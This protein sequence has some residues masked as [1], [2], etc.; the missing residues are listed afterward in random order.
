MNETQKQI[1]E[2]I[3]SSIRNCCNDYMFK[4]GKY[5]DGNNKLFYHYYFLPRASMN[6]YSNDPYE[7]VIIGIYEISK[8]KK[9]EITMIWNGT[10]KDYNSIFSCV[11]DLM[12]YAGGKPIFKREYEYPVSLKDK[13]ILNCKAQFLREVITSG[14]H[15]GVEYASNKKS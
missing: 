7:R 5:R 15:N 9:E 4:S 13:Y 8:L 12:A 14:I 11:E 6:T 10:T 3:D 1:E 2:F